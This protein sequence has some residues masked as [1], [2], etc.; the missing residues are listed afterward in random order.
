MAVRYLILSS[1]C[2]VLSFFR[3]AEPNSEIKD[4]KTQKRI[5]VFFNR[6]EFE[7]SYE[8]KQYLDSLAHLL[9]ENFELLN[10]V[11]IECLPFNCKLELENNPYIGVMR[12]QSIIRYLI[13]QWGFVPEIF[14]IKEPKYYQE[15][16]ES[17]GVQIELVLS[18]SSSIKRK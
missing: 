7:L 5:D 6:N 10:G 12:S 14:C 9:E 17:V 13:D 2:F 16:C 4:I 11:K 18:A 8:N 15:N 3:E 1:I